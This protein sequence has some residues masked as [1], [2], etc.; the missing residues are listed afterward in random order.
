MNRGRRIVKVDGE[1]RSVFINAVE[2][3]H[4]SGRI[5][6]ICMKSAISVPI[7]PHPLTM[8]LRE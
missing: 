3:E 6:E 2:W 5:N 7:Q 8:D 4:L 1:A